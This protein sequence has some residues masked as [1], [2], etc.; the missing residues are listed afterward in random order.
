MVLIVTPNP[1]DLSITNDIFWLDPT[2]IRPY[3]RPLLASML[4]DHAFQVQALGYG[5]RVIGLREWP[6]FALLK[7]LLGEYYG[8]PLSYVVAVKAQS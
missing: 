3:P 1:K 8:N 6:R 7:L 5:N 4:R 2:H